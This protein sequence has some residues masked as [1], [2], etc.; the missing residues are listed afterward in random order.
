MKL[1]NFIS[2][3]THIKMQAGSR[4]L[5]VTFRTKST[6]FLTLPFLPCL[7]IATGPLWLPI[8]CIFRC[9][10]CYKMR[11]LRHSSEISTQVGRLSSW[12]EA[13]FPMMKP[14]PPT[15]ISLIICKWATPSSEATST[16]PRN[17]AGLLMNLVIQLSTRCCTNKWA[18]RRYFSLACPLKIRMKGSPGR[19]CSSSG[20]PTSKT[21]FIKMKNRGCLHIFCMLTIALLNS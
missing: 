4:Q 2:Y 15:N 6:K 8:C 11:L 19:I 5:T 14:V 9:G 16:L 1:S 13:G 10:G 18:L 17:L 21:S 12:M 20:N 7:R 3:L